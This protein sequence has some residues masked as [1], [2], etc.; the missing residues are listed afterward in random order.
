[1]KCLSEYDQAD[2]LK[3]VLWS[4]ETKAGRDEIIA[5]LEEKA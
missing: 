5:L 3:L 4:G 2:A 1:M